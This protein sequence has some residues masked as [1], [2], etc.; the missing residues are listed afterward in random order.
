MA[1][2]SQC[3]CMEIEESNN[4]VSNL[5]GRKTLFWMRLMHSPSSKHFSMSTPRARQC[6]V[7][8]MVILRLMKIVLAMKIIM[9]ILTAMT[10]TTIMIRVTMPMLKMRSGLISF[11]I[12]NHIV[13]ILSCLMILRLFA[14]TIA[15][16]VPKLSW[17]PLFKLDIS[18]VGPP[19]NDYAVLCS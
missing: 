10:T 8:P 1:Q 12:I 13:Y 2:V 3:A 16:W 18:P 17:G 7:P 9:M 14:W 19:L 15:L 4:I 11:H 6:C 5:G